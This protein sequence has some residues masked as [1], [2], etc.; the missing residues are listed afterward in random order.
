[1]I[2]KDWEVEIINWAGLK[3]YTTLNFEG[4]TRKQLYDAIHDYLIN[5]TDQKIFN[6]EIMEVK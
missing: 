5:H 1:M 6:I 2:Q 3:V 4:K